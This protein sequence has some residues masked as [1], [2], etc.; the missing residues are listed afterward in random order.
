MWGYVRKFG[1]YLLNIS[2][3]G[4]TSLLVIPVVIS[5]VGTNSWGQLAV[6]QALGAIIAVFVGFGWG[7]VGPAQIAGMRISER[8]QYLRDSITSRA[9]LLACSIPV[10][11]VLGFVILGPESDLIAYL[12]GGFAT[13]SLALGSGWFFIGESAPVRLLVWDSIPRALGL[14]IAA[15]VLFLTHS[16]LIFVVIQFIF[17]GLSI[18]LTT[19]SLQKRYPEGVYN[20][21][22]RDGFRRLSGSYAAL[23]TAGTSALYVNA[24][25]IIVST[26]L[27]GFTPVYAA[28]EKIQRFALTGMAPVTQIIQGY[29]PSAVDAAGMDKRISRSVVLT[30]S[31]AVVFGAVIAIALPWL[32]HLVTAGNIVVPFSLSI[33]M[34][35]SATLIVIS[36]VTGLAAL[37][38][39]GKQ[40]AVAVSTVIGAAIGLP[41]T[42]V[43]A[44]LGGVVGAAWAVAASEVLVLGYQLFVLS[45][46]LRRK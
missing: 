19:R 40:R 36:G 34:G 8:G 25:L 44:Q 41:L 22:M 14:V 28:A 1:F 18:V 45:A 5:I 32:A 43:M 2:L 20:F 30:T 21:S 31:A 37:V 24:P 35:L 27:P 42:I 9:L 39:L 17:G 13:L 6:A 10:Y 23:V 15:G 11:A 29:I 12:L 38:A 7:I 26:I 3:G 46:S 16:L 4:L 33:P